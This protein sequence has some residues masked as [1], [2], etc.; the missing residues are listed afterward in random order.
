MSRIKRPTLFPLNKHSLDLGSSIS[1]L[2]KPNLTPRS[3]PA[4]DFK[5]PET[6]CCEVPG[7][8][9]WG[10]CLGLELSLTARDSA[11]GLVG[12]QRKLHIPILWSP[13]VT[14]PG[15]PEWLQE[16][17]WEMDSSPRNM[18]HHAASWV[19]QQHVHT[20][21]CLASAPSD[22]DH[23]HLS[24]SPTITLFTDTKAA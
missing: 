3:W 15:L 20:L 12:Y 1:K 18:R 5:S 10:L 14:T 13:A 22:T 2:H 23:L 21:L 6:T 8:I 11:H 17:S 24:L 19:P 16:G 9:H 7:Q 4:A